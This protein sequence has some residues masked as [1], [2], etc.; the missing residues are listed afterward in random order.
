MST[1]AAPAFAEGAAFPPLVQLLAM[2]LVAGN[3]AW[4]WRVWNQLAAADWSAAGATVFVLA[5][6]MVL[7]CAAWI[8]RSR[9]RIDAT[10]IRQSWMWDK[11]VAVADIT[12]ARLVGVPGLSWIIAP[13]LVVRA[14]GKP[15]VLVFHAA[16]RRVLAA[17]AALCLGSMPFR[18]PQPA[19]AAPAP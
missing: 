19:T 15:G 14:R 7:W 16:D 18:P 9:T 5:V 1:A 10:H 3:L 12:Q 11:E 6:A 13:R 2:A 4:G 8:L 17:F